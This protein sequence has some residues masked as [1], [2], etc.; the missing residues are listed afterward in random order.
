[1]IRVLNLGVLIISMLVAACTPAGRYLD[2]PTR[3]SAAVE[4]GAP[5]HDSPT[6]RNEVSELPQAKPDPLRWTSTE[7][8]TIEISRLTFASGCLRLDIVASGVPFFPDS[9][10]P[11]ERPAPLSS[12]LFFAAGASRP[13]V[14]TPIAGG[15]GGSRGEDGILILKQEIIY[16]PTSPFTASGSMDLTIEMSLDPYFGFDE[17]LIFELAAI[18]DETQDCGIQGSRTP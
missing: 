14:L 7:G 16:E 2:N 15:G 17:P 3:F 18:E 4:D 5:L 1:M 13:L 6:R 9:V 10:M 8:I 12:A 11:W